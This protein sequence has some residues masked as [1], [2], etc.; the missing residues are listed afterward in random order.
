MV[1]MVVPSMRSG[2]LGL[3]AEGTP[4]YKPVEGTLMTRWAGHINV[5]KVLPGISPPPDGTGRL[6]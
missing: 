2:S 6:V 3:S 4:G 1:R 5:D